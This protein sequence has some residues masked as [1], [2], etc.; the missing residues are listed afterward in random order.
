MRQNIKEVLVPMLGSPDA[1][2]M[3]SAATCV[4]AIACIELPKG[5]WPGFIELLS[6]NALSDQESVR[7]ASL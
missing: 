7:R 4:A 5:M 1:V 3:K 2:V 6:S